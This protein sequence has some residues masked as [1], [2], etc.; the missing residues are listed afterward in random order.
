MPQNTEDV[1]G[2]HPD[3]FLWLS[4]DV[5]THSEVLEYV[6]RNCASA[7]LEVLRTESAA[8]DLTH[9]TLLGF[10]LDTLRRFNRLPN[11]RTTVLSV[12]EHYQA[13]QLCVAR[14]NYDAK[15]EFSA[16][17]VEVVCTHNKHVR[18]LNTPTSSEEDTE[19]VQKY[20]DFLSHSNVVNQ[21]EV[22]EKLKDAVE[23]Y[24]TVKN[25][26]REKAYLVYGP[27]RTDFL[28]EC[29]KVL[30]GDKAVR[31]VHVEVPLDMSLNASLDRTNI[32][33]HSEAVS[34]GNLPNVD[35]PITTEL[36]SS[37]TGEY[38]TC[39]VNAIIRVLL[40][41]RDELALATTMASPI[42]QLPHDAFTELKRVSLKKNMPMCQCAISH[43]VRLRLGGSNCASSEDS[44]L[45]PFVCG[46]AEFVD[47]LHK[48]QTVIEED[49]GDAA[50]KRVISIIIARIRRSTGFGLNFEAMLS[51]KNGLLDLATKL[52]S[53]HDPADKQEI[54]D[55]VGKGALCTLRNISDFLSTRQI[56]CNLSTLLYFPKHEGTPLNVPA[57]LAYFRTPD[58]E[59]DKED[60]QWN[61]PLSVR[62]QELKEKKVSAFRTTSDAREIEE[63]RSRVNAESVGADQTRGVEATT[64]KR[65]EKLDTSD[66]D[67]GGAEEKKQTA[68]VRPAKRSILS[69]INGA[70]KRP[71]QSG[72]NAKKATKP[73]SS[74]Q[75]AITSFFSI[76]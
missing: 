39:I 73:L 51:F 76:G 6:K 40:N 14:A 11:W 65:V 68:P 71:R 45:R 12:N 18:L 70:A 13:V 8:E 16:T 74:N 17:A 58:P 42:I 38:L 41:S 15:A 5:T 21:W 56:Y 67:T 2:G 27:C 20:A 28:K 52:S 43:I 49:E 72:K 66:K 59:P 29:L 46:L 32:E 69:E 34:I 48:L 53:T 57:M 22:L 55:I 50:V 30:V 7:G 36:P 24:E 26:L 10:I 31:Q 63:E 47:L 4:E 61:K 62:I 3:V 1:L 25:F 33:V 37:R 23:S 75:K 44:P 64:P 35:E 60:E 9:R 19:F 54:T